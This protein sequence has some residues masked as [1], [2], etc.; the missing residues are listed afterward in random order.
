[1]N[2]GPLTRDQARAAFN[3]AGLAYGVLTPVNVRRLRAHINYRMKKSGLIK[4]TYRCHQRGTISK[5][6]RGDVYAIIECKAYYFDRRE[7][8]T[9][10]SD[11]FIGL[12]GW[13]DNEN[14]Q[15]VLAGFIEWIREMEVKK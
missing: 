6:S 3:A 2:T 8:V 15:P 9:F 10:N 11:G 12:A 13:A 14:V 5:N 1:M 7:A 4:G